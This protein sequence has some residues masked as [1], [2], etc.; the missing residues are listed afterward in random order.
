[1]LKILGEF[2]WLWSQ[3]LCKVEF[4]VETNQNNSKVIKILT[5]LGA[6]QEPKSI[7]EHPEALHDS[8]KIVNLEP[9]HHDWHIRLGD[10]CRIPPCQ[11]GL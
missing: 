4:C 7:T 8:P 5:I 6:S 1:M 11:E 9:P 3:R 10:Y 2:E